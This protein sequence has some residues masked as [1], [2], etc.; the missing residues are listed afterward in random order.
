MQ[1]VLAKNSWVVDECLGAPNA[2]VVLIVLK[3]NIRDGQNLG[4]SRRTGGAAE[5]DDP[6]MVGNQ[7][8]GIAGGHRIEIRFH[9][10]VVTDWD[11]V[12]KILYRCYVI[13]SMLAA[14]GG[15][16]TTPDAV[17]KETLLKFACVCQI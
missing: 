5:V 6:L 16:A 12:L 10:R 4:C 13:E 11:A 14:E 15:F 3:P 8:G 2:P 1:P 17:E 9:V 7:C